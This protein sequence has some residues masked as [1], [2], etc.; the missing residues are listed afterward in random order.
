MRML[1]IDYSSASKLI[2][3]LG[4]LGLNTFFS[5]WI[6][7]FLKGCP[8]VIRVGNNISA[9]LTLNTAAPQGCVFSPLLYSLFTHDCVAKHDSNTNIKFAVDT[10]VTDNNDAAY[11]DE[12]RDLALWCQDNNL[13]LNVSKTKQLIVENR[14]RKAKH[15]L[16]NINGAVEERVE[17]FKFLG[18][19][20]T[21]KLS[22]SKHTNTVV[23]RA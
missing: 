23:K 20:I 14:K 21:N 8:Q 16:I 2:T 10:T 11:R 12:V 18:V 22:W 1:C 3:K 19:H 17:S 13:F 5:N 7:D 6:L 9:T 4:T 15:A